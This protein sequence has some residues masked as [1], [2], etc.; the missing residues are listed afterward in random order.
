MEASQSISEPQTGDRT[1][2]K[3]RRRSR[4]HNCEGFAEAW[5]LN[6]ESLFRG[7]IRDISQS[8]CFIR[9]KARL[10]LVRHTIVDLRFTIMNGHYRAATRVINIRPGKGVG[11][12]F[13]FPD[14]QPAEWLKNLLEKLSAAAVPP[15]KP[16]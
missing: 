6:P 14:S 16:T 4:R 5:V 12:E 3:E 13:I 10:S 2:G 7:E 9:S 11:L 15:P 1:E 8:G